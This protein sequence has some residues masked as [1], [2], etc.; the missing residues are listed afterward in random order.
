LGIE[1]NNL[2]L[3]VVAASTSTAL[4]LT[5]AGQGQHEHGGSTEDATLLFSAHTLGTSG[6]K[7]VIDLS[8]LQLERAFHFEIPVTGME[9][10]DARL[11]AI[12]DE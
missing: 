11:A 9:M 7:E 10:N 5:T 12:L 1:V 3:V 8:I 2:Q 4:D 6:T